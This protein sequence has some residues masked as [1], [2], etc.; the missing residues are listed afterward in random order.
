M[1]EKGEF[2]LFL[3]GNPP[4]LHHFFR[5][6]THGELRRRL[7]HAGKNREKI[8]GTKAERGSQP[9][10]ERRSIPEI[11]SLVAESSR[12]KGGGVGVGV[13][14]AGDGHLHLFGGDLEGQLIGGFKGSTASSLH[15][16]S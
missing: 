1:T 6:L 16:I 5:V 10:R 11:E 13:H 4:L 2:I 9:G 12:E 15:V 14:A 7:G 8:R 3:A